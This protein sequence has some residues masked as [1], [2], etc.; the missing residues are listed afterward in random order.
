ML[1]E[2]IWACKMEDQ[3]NQ[4]R[5]QYLP[6]QDLQDYKQIQGIKVALNIA[7]NY[8]SLQWF[9]IPFLDLTACFGPSRG[10]RFQ[11]DLGN[12][13]S[14]RCELGLLNREHCIGMLFNDSN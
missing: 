14:G 5:D 7:M 6:D 12:L 11:L 10:T 2:C 3:T 13:Y 4:S 1:Q 8:W 9:W